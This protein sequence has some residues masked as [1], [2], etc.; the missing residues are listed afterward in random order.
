METTMD[1]KNGHTMKH[2]EKLGKQW[3]NTH[4]HM[5]ILSEDGNTRWTTHGNFDEYLAK[6][7]AYVDIPKKKDVNMVYILWQSN[8]AMGNP[9]K[10]EVSMGKIIE[11]YEG[12]SS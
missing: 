7:P 5:G 6:Y 11:P 12:F 9:P 10:M 8:M 4:T 1:K 2:M 3:M